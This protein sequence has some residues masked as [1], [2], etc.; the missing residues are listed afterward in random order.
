[1]VFPKELFEKVNFE[2][3]KSADAKKPAEYLEGLKRDTIDVYDFRL[4]SYCG[5]FQVENGNKF[6]FIK[7]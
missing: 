6:C 5:L 7:C 3:K 2:G 4:I 1:M